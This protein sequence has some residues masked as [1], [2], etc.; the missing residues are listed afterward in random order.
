MQVS[1]CFRDK[2]AVAPHMI[3]NSRATGHRHRPL[4]YESLE[5]RYV[6]DSTVVFNEL[7]YD[8]AGPTDATLEW[9]ELYNQMSVDMDISGWRLEG[10]VDFAFPEGT[11]VPGHDYIVV[12]ADPA[13]LQSATG[14]VGAWGPLTGQLDNAGEEIRLVNRND[15]RLSVLRYN[16]TDP[17]PVG[18]DGTGFTL[19]KIGLNSA[20]EPAE[21]WTVSL[22]PGGTPGAENFPPPGSSTFEEVLS[23]GEPATYLVP[24]DG[25][26]GLTW[27]QESFVDSLWAS[28]PT[29]IGFDTSGGLASEPPMNDL[30]FWLDAGDLD[31]DGVTTDNQ[32]AGTSVRSWIDRIAGLR[33]LQFTSSA[34]P[35]LST[36]GT[37][38]IPSLS[39]DGNDFLEITDLAAA[40]F[41]NDSQG[42]IAVVY[43]NTNGTEGYAFYSEGAGGQGPMAVVNTLGGF[44][45]QVTAGGNNMVLGGPPAVNDGQFHWSAVTANGSS[46]SFY[47]DGATPLPTGTVIGS[48][49]GEWFDVTTSYS[50]LGV[51]AYAPGGNP[52]CS[53]WEGDIAEM[54]IFDKVLTPSEL[55][56]LN[57]YIFGK[58]EGTANSLVTTD[59]ESEMHGVNSAA[60]IRSDFQVTDVPAIDSMEL[61]IT[62]NDGFV[63]YINGQE[64]ASRNAPASPAWNSSAT[65]EVTG[66][67][68]ES[69]PIS[70][71]GV[72]QE[73]NNTL[74]ILGLNRTSG[75]EDFLILPE[76]TLERLP[77]SAIAV[78]LG[79]NE[80]PAAS[81]SNFWVEIANEGS[82]AVQLGGYVLESSAHGD[83]VFPSQSIAAGDQLLI[84]QAMLG[85]GTADNDKLNLYGPGKTWLL[86]ARR[87]TTRL[88]GRSDQ[89]DERWLYPDVATPG[90][91]NS[92]TFTDDVVINEI[93]YHAMPFFP[94]DDPVITSSLVNIDASTMWQYNFSGDD[95]GSN[96]YQT[97]YSD[98]DPDWDEGAALVG[99]ETNPG[100]LPEP[101]RT[102]LPNPLGVPVSERVITYYFQTTFEFN[103]DLND[104][105]AL[106]MDHVIDDGAVFYLNGVELDRFHIP[107]TVGTPVSAATLASSSVGDASQLGPFSYSASPLVVGTNVLSVEVHQI[108]SGSSDIVMGVE[109]STTS[110]LPVLT[111]DAEEWIELYNKGNS[112]VDL[113]GFTIRGGVDFDIPA[114]TTIAPGEYLVVAHDAAD[115]AAAYPG[116]NVIG[117]FSGRLN[118][119]DDLIRLRDPLD[120]PADEVHYYEGGRWPDLPDGNGSSLELRDPDADN[121][122]AE[123]WAASDET[124]NA[125]WQTYTF[126]GTAAADTGPTG[127]W[128]EFLFG[129]LRAGEVLID[130][131]SVIASPDAAATQLI[132]NGSFE[133]DSVGGPGNKWRIVGNH[134]GAVIVDPDN[135]A[136]QVLHLKATGHTHHEH[137]NA[138]TTFVGNTQVVNGREY[139]IS[140]RAKWLSGSNQL[141]SRLYLSRVALTTLLEVPERAGTPGA[142]NSTFEANVGPTYDGFRHG[143]VV[144]E[145]SQGVTVS[146]AAE[147]PDGVN[148]M[149]LW[150]SVDGG[151]HSSTSM[152][153]DSE[154]RYQGVLPGQSAGTVV[155]FFVEGEDNLGAT[156][157]FPAGGTDSRALFEV[158]DGRGTDNP[159]DTIRTI[160]LTADINGLVAPT[161]ALSNQFTGATVVVNDQ[162][163]YYDV[164][165]HLKGASRARYSPLYW[166]SYTIRFQP[167]RLFRGVHEKIGLDASGS[168]QDEIMLEQIFNH[169]GGQISVYSDLAYSISPFAQH[170]GPVIVELAK[171][172][173]VFFDNAFQNGEDGAVFEYSLVYY[174][175]QTV[176]GNPESLK[177]IEPNLVIG[178]SLP[179]MGNMG[180][181]K[182]SYRW[183]FLI[184]N[185]R[186]ADDY[187]R[188]IAMSQ[189]FS[190]SGSAFLDSVDEVIDVDQWLRINA[191]GNLTGITAYFSSSAQNTGFYVRP[192]DNRVLMLPWDSDS[193]F[194]VG[195][196]AGLVANNDLGKLL[197]SPEYRHFYYG[198]L[199]DII[200]TS[201]NANYVTYWADH[202][203][204]LVDQ[205]FSANTSYVQARANSVSSQVVS[206]VPMVGFQ[207]STS[208]P[209]D[210]GN[211]PTATLTGQGWIDVRE[212]R[213]AGSGV[214]LET[215]WNTVTGWEAIVPVD[216]GNP[217]VTIEA[218]DFQGNLIGTDTITVNTTFTGQPLQDFL[219]ITELMY[220]PSDP[221][222][223]EIAA[224]FT[225]DDAFEY[226]EFYNSSLTQTLDLTGVQIA[227]GPAE[228][229]HF[230]NSLITSLGPDEYMLVVRDQAGFE[231][232]YGASLSHLIAGEYIGGFSNTGEAVQVVTPTGQDIHSFTYA[233]L[234]PWPT[235]PDGGG[236]SLQL[237]DPFSN[238]DH[239][240]AEKWTS[241]V[242]PN[243]SP[244][245]PDTAIGDYNQDGVVDGGDLNLWE[246]EFGTLAGA[247]ADG[248]ED[249]D[250]DGNDFLLWQRNVI[251]A[252]ASA[253]LAA[254]MQSSPLPPATGDFDADGKVDATDID[255]LFSQ[256]PSAVPPVNERYDLVDNDG[257]DHR[258]RDELILNILGTSY[259]DATLDGAVDA[260]DFSSWSVNRFQ[261][262]TRWATADFN[263]DG[264]TDVRDF[265]VWNKNKF[266][267]PP[268]VSAK[269]ASSEDVTLDRDSEH[270]EDYARNLS[271]AETAGRR[272]RLDHDR[273]P[274]RSLEA[275]AIDAVMQEAGDWNSPSVA[276][277]ECE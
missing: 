126:R 109:L 63:A 231:A 44:G 16:D 114:G 54:M 95:L 148:T 190:R 197:D 181:D 216:S 243:G 59:I 200:D 174:P 83:Y 89:F 2:F 143:P 210:V 37:Q 107:G 223:D 62:Y 26:L 152:T 57:D 147:D 65:A 265:N 99:F 274:H 180:D 33:L 155:Q 61:S 135:G 207:I 188:V 240:L 27:T 193:S 70:P 20:V 158:E 185:N 160:M 195:T 249:G 64:V 106:L 67:V 11:I 170:T 146:V 244:G 92:F 121:S 199:L 203:G 258:D 90:S 119:H 116:I 220:H 12:A 270:R 46:W 19:S 242:S 268:I 247:T 48:N 144:P 186:A 261:T 235:A 202:Y 84:N 162:E 212:L 194:G 76:L 201:F 133:G 91:A 120:N 128:N 36:I 169:A 8:P 32:P 103:G 115:M 189:T 260:T 157:T 226:I 224:G 168:G 140:F 221:T 248:D 86:D 149:T 187:S 15:R 123:S 6:L 218:Y 49:I 222:N 139:E 276:N 9:V 39:F 137:N 179:D 47:T 237:V 125:S 196:N 136:N 164:G 74:A 267:A 213:L 204:G 182:E 24:S 132:Q 145:P 233:D 167:D 154:G 110:D 177:L 234:P 131:V 28:G 217:L 22:L 273:Q 225:D 172:G 55:G 14:Y 13:A 78:V 72:L 250:A 105:D 112:T 88:R 191:I 141:L 82:S 117:N 98:L 7:M 239:S 17:W 215:T 241:S 236:P 229:F 129:L 206:A 5:P 101:I 56:Q 266:L 159:I 35:T 176:D 75:D 97:T 102:T 184:K 10:G 1:D 166:G 171:Y 214:P 108:S 246:S 41:L 156:S 130:D 127:V 165:V 228:P 122:R 25:S 58:Y 259:G 104:V 69:I 257:S 208:G 269:A 80:V 271:L 232:R 79:I 68:T 34:R 252:P 198:H 255:L 52:C 73:G 272:R 275:N 60:F 124:G 85:F 31:G 43:S 227:D 178:Q 51:G 81:G 38:S 253:A 230:S 192:E 264:L 100:A 251:Q 18:A 211:A 183:N 71:A 277:D 209:L 219:Q 42:T 173:D 175:T 29:A 262:G 53:G 153:L 205:N 142:A 87:V 161:N 134:H 254:R 151:P 263:G 245:G 23:E 111:D 30:V 94:S 113:T 3:K 77:P 21:N 66:V 93:M 256:I 163:V 150:W 96:W 4:R 118:N 45:I 138:G 40:S 50:R 238:P